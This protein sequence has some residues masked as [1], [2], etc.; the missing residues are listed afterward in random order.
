MQED[1]TFQGTQATYR[2]TWFKSSCQARYTLVTSARSREERED[3]CHAED[4]GHR[5]KVYPGFLQ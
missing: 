3:P 4:T 5:R 1:G 2:E